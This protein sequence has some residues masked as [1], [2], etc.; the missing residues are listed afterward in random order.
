V[1]EIARC[2]RFAIDANDV[3]DDRRKSAPIVLASLGPHDKKA[4]GLHHAP[5]GDEAADAIDQ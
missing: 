3:A 2:E 1:Q 4:H 5:L